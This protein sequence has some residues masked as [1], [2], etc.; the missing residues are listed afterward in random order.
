M[1]VIRLG[2]FYFGSRII[3]LGKV[4]MIVSRDFFALTDIVTVV[5]QGPN[6][7]AGGSVWPPV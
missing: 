2:S 7:E 5:G 6:Q 1:G 4:T 3:R